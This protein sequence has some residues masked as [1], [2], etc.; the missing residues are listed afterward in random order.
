M[1]AA[2]TILRTLV[3]GAAVVVDLGVALGGELLAQLGAHLR[4]DVLAGRVEDGELLLGQVVVDHLRELLDRVVEGLGVGALQLEHGQQRLVPLGV[5]LLAVLGL[6]RPDGVLLAQ[7]GIDVLL[8][9]LGVRDVERGEGAAYGVAVGAAV[10]QVAQQ[11]LEAS[12]VVEDQLHDVT[13]DRSAEVDD[14]HGPT[15]G[16]A[17]TLAVIG[18]RR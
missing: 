10:A 6:V 7:L 9:R 1:R 11:R 8:L 17:P 4:A 15:L 14:G 18:W 16:R 5:L 13:L 2:A 12:V 3:E